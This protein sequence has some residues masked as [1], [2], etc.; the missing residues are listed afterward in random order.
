MFLRL[1]KNSFSSLKHIYQKQVQEARK[2]EDPI[3][4]TALTHLQKLSD[5]LIKTH[6]AWKKNI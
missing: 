5:D 6:D 2:T 4:L 3:Q 1:Y